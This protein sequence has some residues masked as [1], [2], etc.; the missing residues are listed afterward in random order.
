MNKYET[1]LV[2]EVED[3]ACHIY[4]KGFPRLVLYAFVDEHGNQIE[5]DADTQA[6]ADRIAQILSDNIVVEVRG[7]VAY[8]NDPRVKIIDHD[9]H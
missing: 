7:G 3:M 5:S 4:L 1:G 6:E 8:C 2:N 9:N